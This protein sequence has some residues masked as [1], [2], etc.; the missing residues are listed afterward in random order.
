MDEEI[1][2]LI[3]NDTWELVAKPNNQRIVGCKWIYKKKPEVQGIET[4]RFKVRLV[5]KGFTQ[6]EGVDFNEIF[7]PVVK[8]TSIRIILVLVAVQNL[9]LEQMDVK[10]AFLHGHLKEK[11]YMKQPEGYEQKGKEQMVCLLKRSL[12]GLK[13]SLRQWYK[14]FDSFVVSNGYT[15]SSFDSCVYFKRTDSGHFIYLLLYVDDMLIAS[16]DFVA[17]NHLNI[18][19]SSEFEMKDLGAARRILG[20]EITRNRAKGL[21]FLSQSNYVK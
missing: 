8:H 9:E 12:Y 2:S 21:L 15:R 20:M 16:A 1:A 3:K 10:T 19:L 14:R 13:Q 11:I 7:S 17:I 5:G 4:N 18:L 6:K